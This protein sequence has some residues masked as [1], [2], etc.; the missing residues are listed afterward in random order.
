[1]TKMFP[2]KFRQNGLLGALVFQKPALSPVLV[3]EG[4]GS[5]D[6]NRK[7]AGPIKLSQKY[8]KKKYILRVFIPAFEF[9]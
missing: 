5:G 7:K 8:C 4:G 1:M 2:D 6:S 9:Y 3:K